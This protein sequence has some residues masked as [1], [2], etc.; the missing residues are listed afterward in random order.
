MVSIARKWANERVQWGQPIG[1]H[2]AVAQKIARM[3]AYT[4]A[5]E[6]V[7]ELS[8]ALY[9][10]GGYDIRLEAAIAKLFNTEAGWRIIDD[11]L[12]IRGGR[13]YE[14]A[15]SLARRGEPAIPVERAMRDFRINLIFEGSSEIM[16]LFIAREAVDYHFKLAFDIVSPETTFKEK[17]AAMANVDAVLPDV[18]SV[19]LA[20]RVEAQAVRRVRQARDACALHRAR[21]RAI[22]AG[23]S[24]TRWCDS[25]PSSSDGRRCCSARWTSAPSC[26]RC[27]RRARGRRCCRSRGAPR[28]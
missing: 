16:R 17:L 9:E 26:S 15:E 28:P 2:E 22:S 10:K 12:Q 23:R 14:T 1:K 21:R 27:Q 8:A 3:T 11:T 20:Q 7:A 24:S 25:A 5:M 18:V 13:G 4:F 19:A 6:A